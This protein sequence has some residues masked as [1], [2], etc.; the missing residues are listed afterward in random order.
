MR[1]AFCL[2]KYFPFGGLQRDFLRVALACQA[3]GHAIR[4][5]TLEWRGDI[6]AGFELVL[7]P[8]RALS[9]CR[10]YAK[11]SA[12]VA[13]HLAR[14]SRRPVR[15]VQQDAG[16]RRLFCR[17][18]LL[19][20]QGTHPAQP[21]VPPLGALPPFR[22]LRAR[23]LRSGEQDRDPDDLAAADAAVPEVLRHARRAPLHLLPPGIA[24]DR[25][26]PANAAEMRAEFR[27]E[28]GLPGG[29]CC[30]CRSAPASRPRGWTAA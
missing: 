25:R 27:S 18:P 16:P 15:R 30:C 6:P 2:Y 17:R 23:G 19:R 10:R 7:V 5:Y 24:A 26:A 13:A 29:A 12:W 4:V 28:F 8:V 20:R 1:I 11:F 22:R 9:N 3:R 14:R 21:A